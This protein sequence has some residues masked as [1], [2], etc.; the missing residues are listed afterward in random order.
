MYFFLLFCAKAKLRISY[1]CFKVMILLD[2]VLSSD[3]YTSQMYEFEKCLNDQQHLLIFE[4]N[5]VELQNLQV[6]QLAYLESLHHQTAAVLRSQP[7]YYSE[8]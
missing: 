3:V 5:S 8:I 2:F 6:M 1:K 4:L 7:V